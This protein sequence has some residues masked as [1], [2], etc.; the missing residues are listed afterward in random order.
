MTKRGKAA[1]VVVVSLVVTAIHVATPAGP[2]SWHFV[3]LV[4]QKL[5][6]VPILLA[7][8]WLGRAGAGDG[9]TEVSRFAASAVDSGVG[10]GGEGAGWRFTTGRLPAQPVRSCAKTNNRKKERRRAGFTV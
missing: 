8:A 10:A 1:T 6:F 2:H 7:V 5:Y 9:E 4:A 3:H